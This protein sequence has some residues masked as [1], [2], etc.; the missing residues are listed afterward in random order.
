MATMIELTNRWTF[1]KTSSCIGVSDEIVSD[2]IEKYISDIKYKNR[3]IFDVQVELAKNIYSKTKN[4]KVAVEKMMQNYYQHANTLSNFN[5]IVHDSFR[6]K[7][8]FY[9][10]WTAGNFFFINN[11]IGI[12]KKVL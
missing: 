6:E 3:L 10:K 4:S 8:F 1:Y 7:T 9:F 2:L 12:K 11:K 5:S